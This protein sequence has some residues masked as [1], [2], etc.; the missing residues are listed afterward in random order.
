MHDGKLPGCFVSDELLATLQREKIEN[1]I[2]RAAQQVAM[3]KAIGA[4]GVD[5]GGLP[6]YDT[7]VKILRQAEQ[8]G[9]D[10]E[11]YKGNLCWPGADPFY[12]YDEAGRRTT[13]GQRR[14]KKIAQSAFNL[15]HRLILD[16][17]TGLAARFRRA[18]PGRSGFVYRRLP[19]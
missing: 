4:A 13:L 5:V 2:E 10:W 1:H 14:K 7:F 18:E 11:K 3:Y 17:R 16:P 6:D 19:P 12:L 8:I 9:G 15:T